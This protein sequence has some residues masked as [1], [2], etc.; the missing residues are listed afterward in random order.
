[1]S[2]QQLEPKTVNVPPRVKAQDRAPDWYYQV[3][4]ARALR[5]AFRRKDWTGATKG[6]AF[7]YVHVN[8]VILPREQAFD[9]LVLCQRNPRA[10]P[11][12]EVTDVGS[13][14]A[15]A[16][17]PGSDIRTDLPRYRVWRNG[18]LVDEPTD[19]LDYWNDNMVAFLLGCGIG[20]DRALVN[21]GVPVR[22]IEETGKPLAYITNIPVVPAG[23]FYAGRVVTNMR[24]MTPE[25]AIRAT[26]ITTRLPATHGAPIHIG[27]PAAIG[28][29]DLRQPEFGV[30]VTV[31]DGEIPVFW[32]CGVTPQVVAM[33]SKIEFMISHAPGHMFITDKRDAEL[34]VL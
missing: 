26:Q 23:R 31:K 29:K 27:D 19:I 10:C 24:P 11:V 33:D 17:A 12:I 15:K 16:T 8:L 20:S 25:Q 30:P 4:D 13:P 7:G 6:M 32:A 21:A 22:Q 28:I 5:E 34:A 1:M 14:E 9:F 2:V 18:Q 3:D